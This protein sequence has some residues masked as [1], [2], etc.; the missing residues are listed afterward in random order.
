MQPVTDPGWGREG[1]DV[2]GDPFGI[3]ALTAE[4]DQAE[5][6]V[7]ALQ[8]RLLPEASLDVESA[9]VL[10]R[11]HRI[12]K[13]LVAEHMEDLAVPLAD[14][15]DATVMAFGFALVVGKLTETR[16]LQPGAFKCGWCHAA[17]RG[18]DESWLALPSLSDAEVKAH[19]LTCEHNPVARERD[20]ARR[21]LATL[22]TT[23]AMDAKHADEAHEPKS[24]AFWYTMWTEGNRR[25]A[26]LAVELERTRDAAAEATKERDRARADVGLV[27][28]ERDEMVERV[29]KQRDA[30]QA[31]LDHPVLAFI[32]ERDDLKAKLEAA[33]SRPLEFLRE[34]GYQLAD[35]PSASVILSGPGG[36]TITIRDTAARIKA[37]EVG[38]REA[39]DMLF[40]RSFDADRVASLSELAGDP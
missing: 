19:T 20:Q 13:D 37:L 39:L 29:V 3:A 9:E 38:L 17:G 14:L 1:R 30:L 12:A 11:A 32:R 33:R 5:E 10:T 35:D 31:K 36:S 8:V 18:T 22:R 26:E 25:N 27:D 23:L 15:D 16:P 34:N 4:R 2:T 40:A 28:E 7:A 24:S 6:A 21:D